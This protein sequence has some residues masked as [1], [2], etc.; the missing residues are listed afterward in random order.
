MKTVEWGYLRYSQLQS[1]LAIFFRLHTHKTMVIWGVPGR[2]FKYY[3]LLLSFHKCLERK[4]MKVK[5]NDGYFILKHTKTEYTKKESERIV[6][7]VFEKKTYEYDC[8][9]PTHTETYF[10]RITSD[11]ILRNF[12]NRDFA[13]YET[14]EEKIEDGLRRIA[15]EL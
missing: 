9:Y 13:F 15:D 10:D 3:K 1:C 4:Y 14:W 11:P 8:G 6:T 2:T 7:H 12:N 5:T